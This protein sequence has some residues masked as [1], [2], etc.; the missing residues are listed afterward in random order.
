MFKIELKKF[1]LFFSATKNNF[2]NNYQ[3]KLD[4]QSSNFFTT[5]T[6]AAIVPK[7]NCNSK[8]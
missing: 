6:V 7:N 1:K 2:I 3:I 4:E 8:Y 5:F